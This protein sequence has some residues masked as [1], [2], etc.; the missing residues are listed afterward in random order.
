MHPEIVQIGPG[1]ARSAAWRWC[2]SAGAAS[3]GRSRAARP[4]AALLGGRGV[5]R[6][7]RRARDGADARAARTAAA[8]ACEFALATPVVL[9]G[10]WPF[11]HKF[12]LSLEN[13]SPNMY[14]LIGLGVGARLPLQPRGDARARAVPARVPRARRRGRHLFRGGGGDRHAGHA[15]RGDAAA[16]DGP[17]QPGDPAAAR[18]RAQHGAAHRRRRRPRGG[19]AREVQRRRQAAR[20]ARREDPGRRRGARRPTASTNR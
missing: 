12:W 1:R 7:A 14:T 9:W 18:A 13:R 20:A 16:R 2:R 19:A 6:A 4:D 3:E 5:E 10:G 17:D 11:F 8:F 15:R